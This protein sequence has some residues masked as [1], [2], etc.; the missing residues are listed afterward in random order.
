PPTDPVLEIP[1]TARQLEL[2]NDATRDLITTT[3]DGN[4]VL[5]AGIDVLLLEDGVSKLLLETSSVLLTPGDASVFFKDGVVYRKVGGVG[6]PINA[7]LRDGSVPATGTFDFGDLVISR[8]KFKDTS[9]SIDTPSSSAGTLILDMENG[10]AFEVTLTEAV[11][12]LTLSNFPASGKSGT[13]TF[14]AKQ[15]GTGGWDITWP[16]A[17]KWEQDTG[18]SP[19]QTT[20]PN[21]VDIYALVSTDGGT[22]VY[23]FVLGLDMK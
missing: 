17:V 19:G 1:E 5:E 21:A 2:Q 13:M 12:T 4:L 18:L 8:A 10:N 14:I 20:T 16:A 15:D 6:I 3:A 7:F 9:L 22:T 23:G 11:T